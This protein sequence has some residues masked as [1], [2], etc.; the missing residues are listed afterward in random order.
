MSGPPSSRPDEPA[1]RHPLGLVQVPLRS[2]RPPVVDVEGTDLWGR[3]VRAELATPGRWT[4]LLF[5]G[6]RCDGC[7]PFWGAAGAPGSLGLS[8]TD[9]VRIVT[10][11]AGVE[12]AAAVRALLAGLR[13]AALAVMSTPAWRAYGVLGPPFFTAV[14]GAAVRSEG[15]AW[16]V[17]Q[18]AA[19]VARARRRGAPSQTPEGRG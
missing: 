11:D 1:E 8:A 13:A 14:D 17:D 5:L 16:S 2:A 7:A 19:D 15:V 6:S 18:V 4:L 10:R 9:H 3:A 12:D